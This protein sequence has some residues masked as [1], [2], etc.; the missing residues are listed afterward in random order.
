M[1][2]LSS[3]LLLPMLTLYVG[4]PVSEDE[5]DDERGK[6]GLSAH[7]RLNASQIGNTHVLPWPT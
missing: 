4:V 7:G 1:V 2:M 6:I 5:N 3:L